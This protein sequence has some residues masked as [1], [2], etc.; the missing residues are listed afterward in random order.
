MERSNSGEQKGDLQ[1]HFQHYH[2][3]SDD[4]W[5]SSIA[6]RGGIKKRYRYCTDSSG[7]IVYFRA[8]QGH[9]GRNLIDPS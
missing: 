3:W 6:G 8:L 9:P 4:K 7:T 5:K 2:H 1:K